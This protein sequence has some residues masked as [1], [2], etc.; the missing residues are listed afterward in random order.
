VSWLINSLS[1]TQ[2][3][4]LTTTQVAALT[5]DQLATFETQEL[6]ALSTDQFQALTTAQFVT[7]SEAQITGL[8]TDDI[9]AMTTAQAHALT[10]DQIVALTTDQVQALQTADLASMTMTQYDAF[11][12][13]DWAAMS[14]AQFAALQSVTPMVLDLNGD[15]VQTLSAANGVNFDLTGLGQADQVAWASA[16]DGLLVRDIN[17]DG[18]INNG[19]ELFGAATELSNGQRA[20]NGYAAMADLDSNA[21]GK[22]SAAD[23]KFSELKLWV[24][25]DSDGI[26]DGGELKGLV[27]MGVVELNLDFAKGTE[28]NNGN[29][30]SMTS[31]YTSADG[32]QHDMADVWFAKQGGTPALGELLAAPTTDMLADSG[33]MAAPAAPAAAPSVSAF[34]AAMVRPVGDDELL[35]GQPPLI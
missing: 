34:G 18:V 31:S 14:T 33:L 15:G 24:D 35:R 1:T 2:I 8:S 28:F 13:E 23:A 16:Q 26:T 17:G 30:L 21:D 7:L 22:L 11:Q 4:Q 32:S 3:S 10:T 29:L 12:G 20:G 6:G 5:T 27:D 25:A 9:V 19:T